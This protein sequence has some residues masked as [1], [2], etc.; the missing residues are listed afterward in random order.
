L[1]LN[2]IIFLDIDG[3]VIST[4]ANAFVSY[5][6]TDCVPEAIA[7]LNLICEL[8]GAKIVA[9]STHNYSLSPTGSLKTDLIR[10]GIKPEYIHKNWRTVFP[11]ID[12]TKFNCSLRGIGRQIAIDRWLSD[13]GYAEWVCFDDR[14]FT[15]SKNL[16]HIAAGQGITDNHALDALDILMEDEYWEN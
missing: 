4:S 11:R 9:N 15:F 13:F 5:Y 14:K 12:Y 16:I 1:K 7:N 10:F 3:P 2:K 8:S 6:R